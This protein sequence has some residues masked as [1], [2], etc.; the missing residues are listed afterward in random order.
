MS[1][2]VSIAYMVEGFLVVLPI[3]LILYLIG[4]FI[5]VRDARY[6]FR[7]FK[8]AIFIGLVSGIVLN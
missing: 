5:D 8:Y 3:I 6:Y 7:T 4:R 1:K 2:A